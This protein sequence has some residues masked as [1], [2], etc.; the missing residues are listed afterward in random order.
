MQ[1]PCLL[2]MIRVRADGRKEL[3]APVPTWCIVRW[4]A[5]ASTKR[6]SYA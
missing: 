5:D 4:T 3:I 1:K 6:P 2:V